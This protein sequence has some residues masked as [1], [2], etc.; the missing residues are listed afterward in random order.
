MP[1][2]KMAL[3]RPSAC[4]S[5]AG[6][7]ERC[8]ACQSWSVLRAL[9]HEEAAA[10]QQI[11]RLPL[12]ARVNVSEREHAATEHVG[13]FAGIDLVALEIL[14]VLDGST[15]LECGHRTADFLPVSSEHHLSRMHLDSHPAH[16]EAAFF[17]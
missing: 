15:R 8:A 12:G 11:A 14:Q 7:R 1:C 2:C 6:T 17:S 10:A 3:A 16:L 9:P 5:S 4:W 13:E